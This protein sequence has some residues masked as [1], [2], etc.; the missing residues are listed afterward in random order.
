MT[1][2]VVVFLIPW[3]ED[4]TRLRRAVDAPASS[5]R[6]LV[7]LL[8]TA[9]RR[10]GDELSAHALRAGPRR[11]LAVLFI[12]E[13]LALA[14]ARWPASRRAVIGRGSAGRWLWSSCSRAAMR[15]RAPQARSNLRAALVLV[16]RQLGRGLGPARARA[17]QPRSRGVALAGSTDLVRT[18]AAVGGVGRTCNRLAQTSSRRTFRNLMKRFAESSRLDQVTKTPGSETRR[19]RTSV[20]R[21]DRRK[22]LRKLGFVV[23]PAPDRARVNRP[24]HLN[25]AGRSDRTRC[26]GG[27]P[28][29][30]APTRGRTPRPVAARRSRDHARSIRNRRRG[31]PPEAP[32]ASGPSTGGIA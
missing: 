20:W 27:I 17:V 21:R 10:R 7:D 29:T 25:E 11:P 22:Q 24:A 8:W 16:P 15:R 18:R 30:M 5:R 6:T 28:G 3:L 2:L 26:C 13:Y 1:L 12:L 14:P 4:Q 32:R 31:W 23:L 19:R 9:R